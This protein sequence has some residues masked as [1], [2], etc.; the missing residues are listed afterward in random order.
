MTSTLEALKR[1][2]DSNPLK[3][4]DWIL[5]TKIATNHQHTFRPCLCKFL[6]KPD[7]ILFTKDSK[8]TYTNPN[9]SAYGLGP[10]Y[11]RFKCT[12]TGCNQ[13][14][15]PVTMLIRYND[16]QQKQSY[17]LGSKRTLSP[18]LSEKE[19]Q[20]HKENPKSFSWNDNE[21]AI[22]T[23]NVAL[24]T[25]LESQLTASRTSF[26]TES[27]QINLQN[28]N[29]ELSLKMD[30]LTTILVTMKNDSESKMGF[31]LNSFDQLLVNN[32]KLEKQIENLNER[33]LFAENKLKEN[34]KYFTSPSYIDTPNPPSTTD[35]HHHV[36]CTSSSLHN[37]STISW[38]SIAS[39]P[40]E[41]QQLLAQSK[42]RSTIQKSNRTQL[43]HSLSKLAKSRTAL[44]SETQSVYIGGF[45]Y[46][47]L[48]E[49]WKALYTAKFQV[50][51]I[52][53]IQWI[54]RTVLDIVVTSDY[55]LQ[56]VS[57]LTLN[58]KFRIL[59]FNPSC[60]SKAIS[61]SDNEN[62]MQ[63]FSIRCIKN[64]L[65]KSN[66]ALC[67]NHFKNLSEKYCQIN[68]KLNE[69]FTQE[70]NK[71]NEQLQHQIDS[72][73]SQITI[74][75]EQ[76]NSCHDESIGKRM[77]TD[78]KSL[79]KLNPDH[80]IFLTHK[81]YYENTSTSHPTP[82]NYEK[83]IMN[84]VEMIETNDSE[85]KDTHII[86]RISTIIEDREISSNTIATSTIEDGNGAH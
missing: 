46:V 51:R 58:R 78:L 84:D 4:E 62:A 11:N 12:A 22:L 39:S 52:V 41:Q 29:N 50:S 68:P 86:N 48:R 45:E 79:E 47:K 76:L 27:N 67:I 69:I 34:E 42:A 20:P 28:M 55:H 8:Q 21:S 73:A 19:N 36:A 61:P 24:A 18:T 38:A 66:S 1:M 9:H 31:L 71:A 10:V 7:S 33:L 32:N 80:P 74:A 13:S 72:L 3:K 64:I 5:L 14:F 23:Q 65:N 16:F 30:K 75:A 85:L 37:T 2:Q 25:Q 40:P 57:E 6:N 77:N 49:I 70:W 53:N 63:K 82:P 60:N 17:H 26:T 43:V 15:S 44:Q 59:S 56:F 54:G 83:D 35:T 81:S